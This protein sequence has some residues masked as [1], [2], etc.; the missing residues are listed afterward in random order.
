VRINLETLSEQKAV[1]D[2]VSEK[3]SQL[4]YMLQEARNTLRALQQERELAERIEQGIKKLRSKPVA[5]EEGKPADAAA[6]ASHT[7]T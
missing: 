5:D 7:R 4:E 6:Y 1:V 3:A 2:H